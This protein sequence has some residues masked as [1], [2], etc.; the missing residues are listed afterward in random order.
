M[1]MKLY[2]HVPDVYGWQE[3]VDEKIE[4]MKSHDLWDA[5]DGIVFQLHY[6]PASFDD[7]IQTF[8]DDR[9]EFWTCN[10]AVA[11]LS[12]IYSNRKLWSDC[13]SMSN[14]TAILRYH[15]KGLTHRQSEIVWPIAQA[16]SEYFDYWNIERW[17]HAYAYLVQGCDAVGANWQPVWDTP[18]K[19]PGHFS[20]NIWWSHSNYLKRLPQLHKP[21]EIGLAAQLGGYSVRHDAELWV[22]SGH[23]K[24]KELHHFPHCAVHYVDPPDPKDYR[25]T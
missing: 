2:F 17:Q 6:N 23:P 1:K 9:I 12:E 19:I 10:D 3:F 7:W 11:P 8:S 25:L 22:A 20:G 5:L 16:W 14:D 15:T 24:V 18:L 13:Q 4:L 21:H